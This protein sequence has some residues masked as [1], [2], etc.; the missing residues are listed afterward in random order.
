MIHIGL[1]H[2]LFVSSILFSLGIYGIVTRRNAVMVLMGVEL[3]LNA[4]NINFIAF[5][6][7]GNFGLQGQIM[8]LFVIVL[9]AAE[10]AIASPL[11]EDIDFSGAGGVLVNITAGPDISIG[12]F[13]EVGEVVKSF[14][15]DDATVVV[16]TV[17]DPEMS[18]ELRVTVVVTGLGG[19]GRAAARAS[20]DAVA[21]NVPVEGLK[22]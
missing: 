18:D 6:K 10:A 8:A 22:L 14:A 7:Y 19:K 3:M 13:E 21:L 11:L 5:A 17:I 2:F 15:S 20:S 12:E 16:G 9:A 4:S 1:S